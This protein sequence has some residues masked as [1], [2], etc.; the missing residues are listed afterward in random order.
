VGYFARVAPE[1][2]LQRLAEAYGLLRRRVPDAPMRLE[3]AGY[4]APEHRPFLTGVQESLRR[5]GLAAEFHYHGAVDLRGKLDF[6]RS[7]DVLS[8]PASYDEPKGLFLL[9][10]MAAGTPVVQPRRGAFVEIVENTGGGLLVDPDAADDLASG[11]ERLYRDPGQ[12]EELGR[13]GARAVR[14]RYTVQGSADVLLEVY[15]DVRRAPAEAPRP[16]PNRPA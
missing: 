11:L 6:L 10:A 1:K 13:Q 2:G 9:E 14:E 8:V 5:A 3:A 4:L 15:A 16:W 7:L 12:R